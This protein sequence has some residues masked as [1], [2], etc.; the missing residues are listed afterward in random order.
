MEKRFQLTSSGQQ[1]QTSD[2]NLL[3]TESGLAD[4]RVLAELFRLPPG[5]TATKW[6][7]PYGH[8][9]SGKTP[10]V[11]GDPTLGGV[12]VQPFRAF[13]SSRTAV[14]TDQRDSWRGSRS[15][16]NVVEAV[17]SAITTTVTIGANVTVNPRWDLLWAQID[18]DQD[19]PASTIRKIKSPT[20]GVVTAT[21]L[22]QYKTTNVVLGVTPGTTASSTPAWSTVT[23]PADS[24]SSYY[25]PLAYILVLASFGSGNVISNSGIAEVMPTLPVHRATGAQT[26]S[27]ATANSTPT[28]AQQSAW[29]ND[30]FGALG[31]RP[32][33]FLPST[34]V[35]G[36]SLIFAADLTT[37]SETHA[38]NSVIDSR[39]WRGRIC[40]FVAYIQATATTT[41]NFVWRHPVTQSIPFGTTAATYTGMGQTIDF[42][43]GDVVLLAAANI[44]ELP[45]TSQIKIICDASTGNLKL[46]Y[47][48]SPNVAVIVKIDFSGPYSN[49]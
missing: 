45:A 49:A 16:L 46:S 13:I 32:H 14:G 2:L 43:T 6:V 19:A 29:S 12:T 17:T 25:I 48:N 15:A 37:G 28:A 20:T 26:L 9:T 18:V 38:A 23:I 5:A 3:G 36:E 47:I 4:D 27:V 44:A 1:V 31:P 10:M 8:Q 33:A 42:S 39:D 24:G 41:A 34:M 7:I 30:G 21:T 40:T 35:G 22:Y 11:K